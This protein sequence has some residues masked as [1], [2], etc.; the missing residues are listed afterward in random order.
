MNYT[1]G[2]DADLVLPALQQRLGWR[3]PTVA[4]SPVLNSD[5]L[6]SASGRYFGQSFHALCTIN[7]LKANQEDPAISDDDFNTYLSSLQSDMIMRSLNEVFREPELIEEAL[8][9]TR[10]GFND[11]P[12]VNSNQFVGYV[13]NIAN[14]KAIST[15]IKYATLYFN[16]DVSFSLYLYED[17][18]KT[19]LMTI[20]VS[21][22]AWERTQIEFDGVELAPIVL[23]FVKGRRYYFGYYQSELGS[24]QA[25]R[26]QI[27]VWATTYNFEAYPLSAPVDTFFGFNH[28]YRQ[29]PFL[30]GGINLSMI[31]F[32]DHTEK[33]IRKANLFDEL[34]GLQM[35]A[36]CIELAN[37]SVRTNKDQRQT[38][39]QSQQAFVEL[40][41]AFPT[42]D[43]PMTPGIKSRIDRE[44]KRVKETF[45]PKQEAISLPM[46]GRYATNQLDAQWNKQVIRQLKN[47]SWQVI[48]SGGG[49]A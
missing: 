38:E 41:Q 5:N 22:M 32:R 47:P 40:N 13:I 16:Q 49:D 30:P 48:P 14:D 25:I 36:Y 20:P 23:K 34:Q 26:E 12:I 7:N 29:F 15:A 2:F 33:I 28:N 8:L 43:M 9:Y 31:S 35:A 39:Q 18:V 24:A 44:F 4:G 17:G 45:F 11:I 42:K 27:D 46:E 6:T 21:C 1:N 3:Q 10:F 37:N 19:P